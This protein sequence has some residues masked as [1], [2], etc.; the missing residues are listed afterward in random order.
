M[1]VTDSSKPCW[2]LRQPA[3][4]VDLFTYPTIAALA[5]YLGLPQ[6]DAPL[7]LAAVE[8]G[9]RRLQAFAAVR[10]SRREA[11]SEEYAASIAVIGK[12]GRFPQAR[13]VR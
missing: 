8:R 3:A 5:N 10:G 7:K 1:V 4:V 9:N 11:E 12:S 2:P 13:N 6:D